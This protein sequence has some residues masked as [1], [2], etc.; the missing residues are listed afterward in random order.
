LY[1]ASIVVQGEIL[2]FF[3]CF[4]DKPVVDFMAILLLSVKTLQVFPSFASH[5]VSV[6]I[7]MKASGGMYTD[8]SGIEI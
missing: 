7:R 5:T 8:A 1:F 4:D 6:Y 3:V 2:Q